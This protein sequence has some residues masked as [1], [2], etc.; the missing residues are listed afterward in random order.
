MKTL[1]KF[2]A[3]LIL[4]PAACNKHLDVEPTS[5]I[6]SASFWKTENDATGALFGMYLKFVQESNVATF[7]FLGEAR[8]DIMTSSVT[9][10]L[11]YDRYYEQS[12]SASVPGPNWRGLYSIINAANLILKHVPNINFANETNKKNI[13]A[14]AYTMRAYIYFVLTRA[15]GDVPLRVEP[16]EGYD[17]ITIQLPKSPKADIFT[18]IKNDLDQALQLFANNTFP[19]GR[20]FWSKP[21]AHAL[22]ADVYLWTGKQTG[23]GQAD[24]TTALESLTAIQSADVQLLP[25][26]SDIFN[27]SNKGNK[28]ILMAI[29]SQLLENGDNFYMNMYMQATIIPID[30]SQGTRDTIGIGGG[31]NIW[32]PR[33]EIRAQFTTDDQRRFGTFYEIYR[34]NNA[35]FATLCM[36]GKGVI[37]GGQRAFVDDVVVYRY[38]DVLLMIAEAKN[39]LQ[40]DPSAEINLVRQRAYGVNFSSYEFV[41]GT[42]EE[43]DKAIL[44][45][46]LLELMFEGKRWWDLLRFD[47]AFELVPALNSRPVDKEFLLF[48]IGS[49]VLNLEPLV[50]QNKAWQ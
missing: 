6:T 38:A 25:K 18:L 22:K 24:F 30:V 23:G 21:A 32:G 4:V 42:P 13:L 46:R 12:L 26:Y 33:N 8:S 43:N 49:D 3:L 7:Y 17:P 45:E 10:T 48:P 16:T 9:G 11:G 41:N 19:S 35:Y 31:A 15:W 44:K 14:Q 20:C 28:E 2:L 39:A 37:N 40:Q 29:R 27:Y 5:T 1:Y 50:T 34:N 47:K 36:K